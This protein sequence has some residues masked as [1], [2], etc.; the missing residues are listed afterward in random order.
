MKKNKMAFMAVRL[1]AQIASSIEGMASD[2]RPK[3]Q[4][5]RDIITSYVLASRYPPL[6]EDVQALLYRVA[7]V[8]GYGS[9]D[10]LVCDLCNSLERAIRAN[11]GELRDD[12]V[13]V[14]NDILE[15]FS[16]IK[17]D[18]GFSIHK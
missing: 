8:A 11:R 2:A 5:V 10:A 3:Y 15:M 6:R 14:D 9:V 16:D 18:K 12:E 7:A 13:G 1:P 4:V 17:Y